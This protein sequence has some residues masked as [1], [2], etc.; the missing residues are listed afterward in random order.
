MKNRPPMLL[1]HLLDAFRDN[2]EGLLIA[3]YYFSFEDRI[4]AINKLNSDAAELAMQKEH[5][6]ASALVDIR[7]AIDKTT[8]NEYMWIKNRLIGIKKLE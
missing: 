3:G 4:G 2:P 8:D 7:N 1:Q 6:A 5:E